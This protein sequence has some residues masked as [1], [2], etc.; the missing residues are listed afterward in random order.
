[1]TI[2]GKRTQK[3]H[4]IFPTAI[5]NIWGMGKIDTKKLYL[6]ITKLLPHEIFIAYIDSA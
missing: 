4:L 1:V 5:K 3:R 2:S 6:C